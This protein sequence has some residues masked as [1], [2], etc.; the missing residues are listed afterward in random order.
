MQFLL[1]RRDNLKPRSRQRRMTHADVDEARVL[2]ANVLS[3]YIYILIF[4]L[5]YQ[6]VIIDMCTVRS[7]GLSIHI[8]KTPFKAKDRL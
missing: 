2:L 1:R 5:I 3:L 8:N 4:L 7:Y 6:S